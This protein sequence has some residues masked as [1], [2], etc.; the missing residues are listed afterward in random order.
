[1]AKKLLTIADSLSIPQG[2]ALQDTDSVEMECSA[3]FGDSSVVV[4]CQ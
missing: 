4:R 1:M 3:T 2:V